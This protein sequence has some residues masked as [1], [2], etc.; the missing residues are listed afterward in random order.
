[1]VTGKLDVREAAAGLPEEDPL[2]GQ[3]QDDTGADIEPD[4]EDE[5]PE[6]TA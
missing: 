5:A 3:M 4:A 1:M 6:E 2:F